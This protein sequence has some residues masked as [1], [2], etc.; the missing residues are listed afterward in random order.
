MKA[1]VQFRKNGMDILG[2]NGIHILDG[3]NNIESMIC[4]VEEHIHRMRKIRNLKD[5]Q[6]RKGDLDRS[7]VVYQRGV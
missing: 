1:Y 6:I 7:V 5:F 4:D 2:S 3:R